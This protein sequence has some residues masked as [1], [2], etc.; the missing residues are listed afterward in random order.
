VARGVHQHQIAQSWLLLKQFF[1]HEKTKTGTLQKSHSSKDTSNE[2]EENEA[3]INVAPVTGVSNGG[4][5]RNR[6]P[7]SPLLSTFRSSL[8]SK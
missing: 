1:E 4:K 8:S 6:Y 3:S 2:H 7:N 5:E